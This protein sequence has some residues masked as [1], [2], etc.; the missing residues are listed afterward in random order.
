M[1]DSRFD[2]RAAADEELLFGILS[3]HPRAAAIVHLAGETVVRHILTKFPG[4]VV[5][6]IADTNRN[7]G[8]LAASGAFDAVAG[9]EPGWRLVHAIRNALHLSLVRAATADLAGTVGEFM[10]LFNRTAGCRWNS[11][12]RNECVCVAAASMVLGWRGWSAGAPARSPAPPVEAP[13]AA[14]GLAVLLRPEAA[15]GGERAVEAGRLARAVAHSL[16]ADFM[17]AD[18]SLE[19]YC[20]AQLPAVRACAPG[21]ASLLVTV[22]CENLDSCAAGD[23]VR[24]RVAGEDDCLVLEVSR[25][26]LQPGGDRVSGVSQARRRGATAVARRLVARMVARAH[27]AKAAVPPASAAGGIFK[28]SFPGSAADLAPSPAG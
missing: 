19:Y 16:S 9:R 20:E 24:L 27:G 13:A 28:M 7:A 2:F 10:R 15:P 8:R 5:V 22:L 23:G 1:S 25:T 12:R 11:G 4:V 18:V 6:G 21:L 14:G 3:E 17:A 26:A